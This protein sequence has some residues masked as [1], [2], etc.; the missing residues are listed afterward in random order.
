M[1]DLFVKPIPLDLRF[2]GARHYLHGTDI[3]NATVKALRNHVRTADLADIEFSFHRQATFSLELSATPPES[4]VKPAAIVSF[5]AEGGKQKMFLLETD[6]AVNGRYDYDETVFG[7]HLEVSAGDAVGTW[8]HA[9]P[10]SDIETWVGLTKALHQRI[11]SSLEGQWLFVRC[12][13]ATLEHD[14]VP[15][16]RRLAIVSNF[17]NRLTRTVL[18]LDGRVVGEIHFSLL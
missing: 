2:K 8:R 5:T 12:K 15:G 14:A 18:S 6:R 7:Q 3:V 4:P 10:Y 13:F 1:D 16:E 11:F 9:A 17:Q